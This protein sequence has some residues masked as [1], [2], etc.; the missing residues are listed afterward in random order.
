MNDK[1]LAQIEEWLTGQ[2][3]FKLLDTERKELL[4]LKGSLL[5]VWLAQYM[6]ESDDQE[7]WLSLKTL[8][9]LTG[10]SENT[11]IGARKK[12]TEGGWVRCH[13][14]KTAAQ[15]YE[16][17]TR[18]AHK[19]SVYS[20]DDPSSRIEG[21]N[22]RPEIVPPKTEDKVYRSGS[23]SGSNSTYVPLVVA[24]ASKHACSRLS[25]GRGKTRKPK[26]N[27]K[28]NTNSTT[29]LAYT[30]YAESGHR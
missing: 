28:T 5:Q 12:L 26:T 9:E 7:S 10:L 4:K 20:V 3:R 30:G 15:K 6:N 14:G 2:K 27:S 23:S 22:L 13:A 24:I 29:R 21:A 17:P 19:V 16:K 25:L 1:Q 8:Q 18:G 11:V